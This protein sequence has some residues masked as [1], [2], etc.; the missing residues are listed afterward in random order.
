MTD[1]E[2]AV[3]TAEELRDGEMKQISAAGTEILLARVKG[4]YHAVAAH[5]THYGA[6]LVDG[7]LSGER[8]ICPWHHACFNATTGDLEEPPALDSLPCFPAR[9]ENGKV[10]V[11]IP[12]D[13]KDRRTSPMT[14]RQPKDERVFVVVGGGAAG[15]AAVQTLREDGFTGRVILITRESHLPYDRPNLSKEYLQ[16]EADPAWLPLRSDQFFAAHDIEVRLGKEIERIDAAKKLISFVDGG[17]LL[18][19]AV[20]VATGGV[21][22]QLPFQTA[23]QENVF[24]L[25][26]YA[27]SDSIVAAADKGK[28]AIVIGGSFIGME[29]A[30]SLTKRGCQVTVV[31]PDDVPFKKILGAEIG[32]LFQE[33]H[34]KNGVTFR[35][36]QA[37]AAGILG[38][39]PGLRPFRFGQQPQALGLGSGAHC[40]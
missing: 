2:Q 33:V 29:V 39:D 12:D 15:Y 9:I 23:D 21:P 16:G 31:A 1:R 34:E 32:W 38:C 13:A 25:R 11:H 40:L 7:V 36:G 26:S 30:S 28:R 18:A 4:N 6:P 35:L 24:L 3:A 8:I 22:R 10:L 27:D 20:L 17:S 19:D 5:C 37:V 14:K